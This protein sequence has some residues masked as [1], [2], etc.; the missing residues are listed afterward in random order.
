MGQRVLASPGARNQNCQSCPSAYR[1]ELPSS[2]RIL[3]ADDDAA[4]RLIARTALRNLGHECHTVSDGEQAWHAFQTQLPDVVIS[5]LV[6]PGLTGPQLCRK[7]RNDGTSSYVYFVMVSG[8]G[9]LS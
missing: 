7:I 3:V 5:G 6:M 1:D 2:V 9:L 4:S 8:Q